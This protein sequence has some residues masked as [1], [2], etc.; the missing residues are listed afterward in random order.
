LTMGNNDY[1]T[2]LEFEYYSFKERVSGDLQ[3]FV[4]TNNIPC[5]MRWY[6]SRVKF[7]PDGN[8]WI[9]TQVVAV[10]IVDCEQ[11]NHRLLFDLAWSDYVIQL[12]SNWRSR[13]FYTLGDV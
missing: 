7:N 1:R 13:D 8:D 6:M 4:D 3:K 5:S 12:P 9:R 11:S 10:V 2:A